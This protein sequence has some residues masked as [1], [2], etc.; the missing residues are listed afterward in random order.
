LADGRTIQIAD[1][2][3]TADRAGRE[4]EDSGYKETDA[5]HFVKDG[6]KK[7][8]HVFKHPSGHTVTYTSDD[9]DGTIETHSGETAD[10]T[11]IL[12]NE[13]PLSERRRRRSTDFPEDKPSRED[14]QVDDIGADDEDLDAN[15]TPASEDVGDRIPQQFRSAGFLFRGESYRRRHDPIRSYC[16]RRLSGG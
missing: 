13:S 11:D 2:T 15:E 5:K 4:L 16:Q 8:V 3:R 9:A 10:D 1:D 7:T 14:N 12:A 6:R